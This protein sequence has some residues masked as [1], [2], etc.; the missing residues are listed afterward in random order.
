MKTRFIWLIF[1]LAFFITL[2]IIV[3]QRLS[4]EAMAVIVG[5]VAGVAASIPTS[6][7]VVWIAMRSVGIRS[8]PQGRPI[9]ETPP[10]E[11]RIVVVSPPMTGQA[12]YAPSTMPMAFS[13]YQAPP[14]RFTV[15][16]G[17]EA[18]FEGAPTTQEVVWPE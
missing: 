7:I 3:A 14:R 12:S 6:L 2:A 17:S 4:A 5:V 15:I 18:S 13:P 9:A 16:G 1:G 11:P 10:T 8:E